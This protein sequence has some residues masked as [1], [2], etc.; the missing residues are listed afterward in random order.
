MH[1]FLKL[2]WHDQKRVLLTLVAGTISGVTAVALFAQ[3]G[4][5]ISKAALMPPFYVILILTAF[6]KL[7]GVTKSASK[8]AER[9]LSHRV[10]FQLMDN[11]RVNFFQQL[12]PQAHVLQR[13]KSGDLLTRITHDVDVLQHFFLRVLYPPLVTLLVFFCTIIFMLFFSPWLALLLF[14]GLLFTTVV[15]PAVLTMRQTIGQKTRDFTVATTEYFYGYQELLLHN[16]QQQQQ[17]KLVTLAADY[18]HARMRHSV[19]EQRASIYNQAIALIVSFFILFVGAYAVTTGDLQGV[20]LA[21]LVLVSLTVFETAI[22]MAT[23]PTFFKKTKNALTQL[24]D[25]TDVETEDGTITAIGAYAPMTLQHV[26][27]TYPTSIR[28]ALSNVSMY[29]E[30]G[31]KIAII[32]ASGSGKTTLMQLLLKELTPTSG[33][34]FLGDVPLHRFERTSFYTHIG[35]MLQ[36]N[37]FF[38]GT[39]RSNLLFAQPQATDEQLVTALEQAQLFK[40]LETTIE[41]KGRN[42]SGGE[43]Q[44]LA[45]ARLLLKNSDCWL[46]DE[47]FTSMDAKTENELLHT[48]L[49]AAKH[50]TV[51]MITHH[52]TQ[53]EQFDCIYVMANGTIVE[54]G[55]HAQLLARDGLYASMQQHT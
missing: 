42:L 55:P 23:V 8:Y 4:L 49:T 38:A 41:E 40:S 45:F 19:R 1:T 18:E 24:A 16:V 17:H 50:K 52:L 51:V 11:I 15:M 13:Y 31:Q 32:G 14:V 46:I 43:K 20:Y 25:V 28:P 54:Y 21:M 53:L 37:H 10:T 39:I 34:L 2:I 48:M 27:Y 12:V 30:A 26:C 22:P 3:S 36:H 29:I 33:E 5:L 6:L 35:A 47:P 7:F 9:L 44:R